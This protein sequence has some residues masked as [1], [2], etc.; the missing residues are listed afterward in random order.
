MVKTP[1]LIIGA[2][3]AGLATAGRLHDLGIEYKILERSDRLADSWERHYDRLHLHTI[4]RFSG[5]P[6][7]PLPDNLPLYVP[8]ADL[9]SY[10]QEYARRFDIQPIFGEEV[11]KVEYKGD[12]WLCQTQAGNSYEAD[13]VVVCTGFNRIPNVPEF[14]GQH[15][16]K[17]SIRHS[18]D[19]KNPEPFAGSRVLVVGM[20]NSGAEIALD[21][22]EKG[23]D[24][25]ISLRGPIN[26]VP[27]DLRGRP[28]QVTA[29]MIDKLPNPIADWIGSMVQRLSIGDLSA[30]GIERPA[31]SPR[32]QL[33]VLAKTPVLDIGT[34]AKI[35]SGQLQVRPGI[36]QLTA[37]EVC[38][39]D[40]R[41]ESYDHL[42]LATGY[43]TA[44]S[45]FIENSES[46]LNEH[47]H[48]KGPIAEDSHSDLYFVGFDAYS[49]GLLESIYRDS[50]RVVAH[51]IQKKD[52]FNWY[53]HPEKE[54]QVSD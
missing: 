50:R 39:T 28:T 52:K 3:P 1:V 19:Y 31:I 35:R 12:A 38:F 26:I 43:H 25:S 48:P 40:G 45:D 8:R 34:V 15:S 7:Y 37:K 51:M 42:V 6:H 20:G 24:T 5:L 46:L 30:F 33:R 9:V 17:G 54:R 27:R 41:Q 22:V 32:K 14:P 4:K 10:Y 44:V 11:I 23:V 53:V 13:A 16:F 36:S 29:K 18:R 21:L 49:S 2:G 47:G